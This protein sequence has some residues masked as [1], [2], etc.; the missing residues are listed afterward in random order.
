MSSINSVK[1][2]KYSI[3]VKKIAILKNYK[4]TKKSVPVPAFIDTTDFMYQLLKCHV[5]TFCNGWSFILMVFF[6]C[7]Y[8]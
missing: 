4:K 7:K 2:Y 3:L 6:V 5:R 1:N 8:P